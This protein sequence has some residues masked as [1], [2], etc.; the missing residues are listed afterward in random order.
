MSLQEDLTQMLGNREWNGASWA[1]LLF[2]A[3]L[4]EGNRPGAKNTH[5]Q[6]LA[7]AHEFAEAM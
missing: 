1:I 2:V 3:R 7:E 5:R 6:A 4:K